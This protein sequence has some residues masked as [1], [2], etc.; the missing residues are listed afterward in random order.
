MGMKAQKY[1]SVQPYGCWLWCLSDR[2]KH[3]VST[4]C[5]SCVLNQ[6]Y[7]SS[8]I[9]AW[10]C[11]CWSQRFGQIFFHWVLFSGHPETSSWKTPNSH[12]FLN[13]LHRTN[14]TMAWFGKNLT[15][16]KHSKNMVLSSPQEEHHHSKSTQATPEFVFTSVRTPSLH[17]FPVQVIHQHSG[18]CALI[19]PAVMCPD[20]WWSKQ[21]PTHSPCPTAK[22]QSMHLNIMK[23]L[24]IELQ[25]GLN[26]KRP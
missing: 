25:N 4:P 5:S 11:L 20:N 1:P 15:D 2:L 18:S 22:K 7:Y 17:S 13:M 16:H 10:D 6:S 12:L 8:Y 14:H 3:T 21:Y 24:I 19:R 26:W 9:K 23:H